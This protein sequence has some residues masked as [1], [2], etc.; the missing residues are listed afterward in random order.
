MVNNNIKSRTNTELVAYL[1]ST[2]THR[3]IAYHQAWHDNRPG[4]WE[5]M[6]SLVTLIQHELLLRLASNH[7]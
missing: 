4:N 6:A 5:E 3:E 2:V 1:I 7:V